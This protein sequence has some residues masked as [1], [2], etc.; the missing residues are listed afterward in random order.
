MIQGEVFDSIERTALLNILTQEPYSKLLMIHFKFTRKIP[1]NETDESDAR[2]VMTLLFEGMSYTIPLSQ[3]AL[4]LSL[5]LDGNTDGEPC[6]SSNV[7]SNRIEN[8][9]SLNNNNTSLNFMPNSLNILKK[10]IKYDFHKRGANN[11]VGLNNDIASI[12]KQNNDNCTTIKWEPN[13]DISYISSTECE[14]SQ[15]DIQSFLF[16]LKEINYNLSRISK[17]RSFLKP[18][19]K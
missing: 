4:N 7:M 12:I 17:N 2:D 6:F 15:L 3:L 19:I 5:A 11:K 14:S 9:F 1:F 13:S 16:E 10:G 8:P 18:H